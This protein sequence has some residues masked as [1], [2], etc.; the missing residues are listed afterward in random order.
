MKFVRL[1]ISALAAIFLLWNCSPKEEKEQATNN[2]DSVFVKLS[3]EFLDGYL[4]WR[5]Q[6]GTYLGLHQYDGKLKDY[7]KTSIDAEL[8]RLKDFES[9]LV[10]FAKDSLSPRMNYD[11]RILLSGL[12]QEIF[13]IEELAI[14]SKNPMTYAG[15]LD[16]NIYVQRNFAP[17][18]ER[19]KSIIAIEEKS[20]EIFAAARANLADSLAKPY[21]ETAI[22]IAR[23][24]ASFLK[25]ELARR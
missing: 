18:E 2:P 22:L 19:M 9:R 15:S 17:L 6:M 10:S 8:S 14:Y 25:K 3:E 11:Y 5:P 13:A 21:V 12:R 1:S 16:L 20:P 4:S 7:S 24:G 23:G